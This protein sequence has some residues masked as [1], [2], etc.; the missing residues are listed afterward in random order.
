M[1]NQEI[2]ERFLRKYDPHGQS[3]SYAWF[4][5]ISVYEKTVDRDLAQMSL[6]EVIEALGRVNI[7]TYNTAN[8]LK[9]FVRKYVLWCHETMAFDNVNLDTKSIKTADIDA[10]RYLQNLWFSNEDDLLSKMKTVRDFDNGYYE[11]VVM[12]FAWIGIP[13]EKVLAIRKEDVDIQSRKITIP[14]TGEIFEFSDKFAEVISEYANTNIATR[15]YRGDPPF[16]YKYDKTGLFVC[17]FCF[18][19]EEEDAE[20]TD[21]KIVTAISKMNQAYEALSDHEGVFTYT[22]A[23]KCGAMNRVWQLERSGVDVFKMSNKGQLKSAFRLNSER[24]EILWLYKN[25]KQAFSL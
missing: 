3:G 10:S 23:Q 15:K 20:L 5:A 17:R 1:Y 24:R 13:Q 19:G 11:V 25:Y 16:V 14:D 2:K 21:S 18:P 22:N 4:D 7:G 6:K 12:I 8:S 9:N